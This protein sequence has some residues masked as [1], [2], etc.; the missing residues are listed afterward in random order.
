M[1]PIL[2]YQDRERI[3]ALAQEWDMSPVNQPIDRWVRYAERHDLEPELRQKIAA[4]VAK[5]CDV[6]GSCFIKPFCDL[7]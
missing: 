6:N 4:T 7:A 2:S 5:N 3:L 1:T